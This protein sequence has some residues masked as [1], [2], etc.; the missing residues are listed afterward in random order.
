MEI[1]TF[2]AQKIGR[3]LLN[4]IPDTHDAYLNMQF[5][6]RHNQTG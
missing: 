4:I 3:K 6:M 1:A 2:L 5:H